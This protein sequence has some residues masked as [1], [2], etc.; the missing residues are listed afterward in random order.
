MS[1]LAE[2]TLNSIVNS[3][4]TLPKTPKSIIVSGGGYRNKNLIKQLKK[5]IKIPFH[6]LESF[7]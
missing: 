1:T 6:D 5:H 7:W 3:I 4:K 2:V